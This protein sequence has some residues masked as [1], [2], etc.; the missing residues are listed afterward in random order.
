LSFRLDLLASVSTPKEHS[1][2][3]NPVSDSIKR[4]SASLHAAWTALVNNGSPDGARARFTASRVAIHVARRSLESFDRNVRP[5]VEQLCLA[6]LWHPEELKARLQIQEAPELTAGVCL[7][8]AAELT[9]A[10]SAEWTQYVALVRATDFAHDQVPDR[11]QRSLAASRRAV[12]FWLQRRPNGDVM[13][14]R[15]APIAL[16][17][18]AMVNGIAPVERSFTQLRTT[19]TLRRLNMSHETREQESYVRFNRRLLRR[20]LWLPVDEFWPA[21]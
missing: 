17:V 6:L 15:L 21:L 10:M 13:F 4:T 19:Q 3:L 9:P 5:A 12:A 7:D 18:L 11:N 20:S 2:S 14:P 8:Y 16:L 1:D